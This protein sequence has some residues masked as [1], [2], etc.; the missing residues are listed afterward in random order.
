MSYPGLTW[1]NGVVYSDNDSYPGI[2]SWSGTNFY[3]A[4][5]PV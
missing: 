2:T 5:F 1:V 4:V 3:P